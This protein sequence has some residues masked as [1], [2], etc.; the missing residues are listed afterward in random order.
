WSDPQEAIPLADQALRSLGEDASFFNA[1][2]LCMKGQAQSLTYDRRSAVETL[3]KAVTLA[4]QLG[5]QFMAH[6]ALGHLALV[7]NAQG[8]LREALL[9][10]RNA[11]DEAADAVD[12]SLPIPRPVHIPLGAFLYQIHDSPSPRP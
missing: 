3:R 10:C 6:D 5:N 8:Q 12:H 9:L 11:A 1:Y 4:R 7:L 2:V